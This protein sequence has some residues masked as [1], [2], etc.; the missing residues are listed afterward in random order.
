MSDGQDVEPVD[1]DLLT[2]GG[3]FSTIEDSAYSD[4]ISVTYSPEGYPTTI[5]IDRAQNVIDEELRIDVHDLMAT[6][7]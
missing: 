3:L 7:A 4:E 1:K 6:D 2:I 5:D